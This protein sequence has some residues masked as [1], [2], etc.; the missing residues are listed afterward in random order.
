MNYPEKKAKAVGKSPLKV[1]VKTSEETINVK[2][3]KVFCSKNPITL[4][5]NVNLI[6]ADSKKGIRLYCETDEDAKSLVGRIREGKVSDLTDYP[7]KWNP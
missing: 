6:L 3:I 7:A 5:N 4:Q 2:V 1:R